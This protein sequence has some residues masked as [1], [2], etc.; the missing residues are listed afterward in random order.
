[1]PDPEDV[2]DENKNIC[3]QNNN[4]NGDKLEYFTRLRS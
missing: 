1:M 3:K 2:A 4:D